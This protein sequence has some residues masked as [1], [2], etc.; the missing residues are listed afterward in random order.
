M[1][2]QIDYIRHDYWVSNCTIGGENLSKND[3]EWLGL[4]KIDVNEVGRRSLP[5]LLKG[6]IG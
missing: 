3:A 2:Y 6:Y 4:R 1:I 5:D